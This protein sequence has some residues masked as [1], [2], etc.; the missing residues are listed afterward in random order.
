MKMTKKKVFVA[1]LAICLVAILSIGTLAWFSDS[2]A[3]SN[4]FRVAD[5][6]IGSGDET[7]SVDLWEKTPESAKDEDGY[8][9][10]EILP[11]DLLVKEPHVV[12]TGYYDQ[13]IRVIVTIS[14][15][16]NW[17][18]IVGADAD[19]EKVFVGYDEAKWN[20]ISK[21]YDNVADT[22]TYVLYYND[23]LKADEEIVLFNSVKISEDMTQD[24]AA[25]FGGD[26]T[27][28]VRAQAVQTENVGANAFE[29]FA[30]V[31]MA[32]DA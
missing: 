5:T 10:E 28:D 11:G 7:F 19:M 26:F 1:A 9:Y 15:A 20:N 12:N 3:V 16:A 18:N 8:T 31:G 24:Q 14:D 13:Y 21:T 30:T 4:K 22:L 29:A 23:I 2:E 32:I 17:I 6:G 25:A 27:V